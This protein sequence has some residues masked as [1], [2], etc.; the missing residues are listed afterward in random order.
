M[1]NIIKNNSGIGNVS[2]G[3]KGTVLPV[4]VRPEMQEILVA[5]IG[6]RNADM[7]SHN[8]LIMMYATQCAELLGVNIEAAAINLDTFTFEEKK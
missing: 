2:A 1:K 5:M 3:I 8:R 7:E 6:R 4:K